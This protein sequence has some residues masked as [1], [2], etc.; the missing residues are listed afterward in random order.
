MPG[1][2]IIPAFKGRRGHPS[3]FPVEVISGIFFV[4]TLRHLIREEGDRILVVDVSDEGIVLDRDTE[5]DYRT[6]A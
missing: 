4:P 5:E 2:L 3:L 1:K 6:I